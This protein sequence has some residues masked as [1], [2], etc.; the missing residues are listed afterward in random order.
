MDTDGPS[1]DN[2]RRRK[3]LYFLRQSCFTFTSTKSIRSEVSQGLSDALGMERR[4]TMIR[5][6]LWARHKPLNRY[7]L[8]DPTQGR[9]SLFPSM[10]AFPLFRW[11]LFPEPGSSHR[12][13]DLCKFPISPD[14]NHSYC[15]INRTYC[16]I[17]FVYRYS[18][19]ALHS[20]CICTSISSHGNMS[21]H[22]R[23]FL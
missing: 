19:V 2:H 6:W 22:V 14:S 18:T 3:H 21:R 17:C 13:D 9:S 23:P 20:T 4:H 7:D 5:I 15:P 16:I 8:T 11:G 1:N 12:L 10:S